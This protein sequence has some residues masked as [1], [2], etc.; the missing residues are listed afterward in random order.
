[1]IATLKDFA[2]FLFPGFYFVVL[3]YNLS[4]DVNRKEDTQARFYFSSN[5][6]YDTISGRVKIYNSITACKDHPAFMR[7]M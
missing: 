2:T 4:V 5:G 1:M 6:T 3:L 7:V